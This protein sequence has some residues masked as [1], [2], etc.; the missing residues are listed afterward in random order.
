M[1]V[2]MVNVDQ[3]SRDI[4][5]K[6]V[7]GTAYQLAEARGK[8]QAL[9]MLAQ[10]ADPVIVI[11][12]FPLALWQDSGD[13]LAAIAGTPPLV[14]L[15]SFILLL[16]TNETVPLT[17]GRAL[18]RLAAKLVAKPINTTTLLTAITTAARESNERAENAPTRKIARIDRSSIDASSDKTTP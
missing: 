4:V 16:Y 15:H 14:A 3:H 9:Q 18:A 10:S 2:L 11:V 12:D 5:V 1:R 17:V 8:V 13:M 7:Q 6:S